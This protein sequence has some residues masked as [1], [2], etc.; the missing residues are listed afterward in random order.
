VSFFK[1]LEGDSLV[2]STSTKKIEK[3]NPQGQKKKAIKTFKGNR[4]QKKKVLGKEQHRLGTKGRLKDSYRKKWGERRNEPGR[5]FLQ[6]RCRRNQGK[7][8]VSTEAELGSPGRQ[9]KNLEMV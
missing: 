3:K 7:K 1:K 5:Q 2:R 8:R 9:K 4:K 6:I